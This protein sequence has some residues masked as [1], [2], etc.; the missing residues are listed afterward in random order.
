[1][2]VAADAT[3]PGQLLEMELHGVSS[4]S[5]CFN[6]IIMYTICY[7]INHYYSRNIFFSS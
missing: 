7:D 5:H 3:V 6:R 4:S 1:M 2:M